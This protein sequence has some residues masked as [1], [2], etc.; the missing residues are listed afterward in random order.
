[1]AFGEFDGC[2]EEGARG[3]ADKE[4]GSREGVAGGEC[5]LEADVDAF[6]DQGFVEDA[7]E[8]FYVLGTGGLQGISDCG[9]LDGQLGGSVRE[10]A[11]G[12][13]DADRDLRS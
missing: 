7:C 12:R 5:F 3:G 13:G 2:P 9:R 1:V 10:G 4:P 8:E 11:Q 6:G